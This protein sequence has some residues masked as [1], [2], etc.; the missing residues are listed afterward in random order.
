MPV[1][2]SVASPETD[3]ENFSGL[4][5]MVNHW[6]RADWWPGRTAYYW[7]LTWANSPE[8][9]SM[10]ERCQEPF[11]D[12]PAFDVVKPQALHMTLDRV[13]F[14][15]DLTGAQIDQV[16]ARARQVASHLTAFKVQLGPLAGSAGA[17]SFSAKP[18][19]QLDSLRRAMNA[20]TAEVVSDVSTDLRFRPH[21]GVAYCNTPIPAAPVID[22]VRRLR[23]VPTTEA[24]VRTVALVRLT[25]QERAYEWE[26]H[27][28]LQLGG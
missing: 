19:A 20:A 18:F 4:T 15:E 14:T 7:Y 3:W 1:T 24:D 2:Q 16:T 8:V 22:T 10:A 27:E 9:R 28:V 5:T 13:G 21:V 23:A 12:N 17:L 26:P 11:R 25:R 6:D